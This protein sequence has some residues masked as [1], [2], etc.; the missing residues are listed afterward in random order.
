MCFNVGQEIVVKTTIAREYGKAAHLVGNYENTRC[1]FLLL[2][3]GK[4]LSCSPEPN[5]IYDEANFTLTIHSLKFNLEPGFEQVAQDCRKLALKG[6]PFFA[7]V[8]LYQQSK[9]EKE[10]GIFRIKLDSFNY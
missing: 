6:L 5:G 1:D 3:N 9:Q 2:P 8:R 4:I 7:I 10:K